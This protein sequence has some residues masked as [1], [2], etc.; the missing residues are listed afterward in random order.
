M[1]SYPEPMWI[2]RLFLLVIRYTERYFTRRRTGYMS[3]T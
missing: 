1:E 2:K 3:L